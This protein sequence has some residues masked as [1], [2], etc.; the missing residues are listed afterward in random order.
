MPRIFAGG[1]VPQGA[2]SECVGPLKFRAYV[3]NPLPQAAELC[4]Q[5]VGP[6]AWLSREVRI[7]AGPRE[8]VSADL[9][10]TPH[11]GVLCRRQPIAL[12]LT[13]GGQA[14]GQIAEALVTIGHERW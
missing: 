9:E 13:V 12:E 1:V 8:E 4:L 7:N 6:D 5:L 11:E 2:D 3:R 10:I 14:Y